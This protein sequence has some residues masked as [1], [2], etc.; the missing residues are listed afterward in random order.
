MS[1]RGFGHL[2]VV[3][4]IYE[5]KG[6]RNGQPYRQRCRFVDTWAFKK[7]GWKLIASTATSAIS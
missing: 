6:I 4:G 1:V 5:E 7:T 3:F 2:A